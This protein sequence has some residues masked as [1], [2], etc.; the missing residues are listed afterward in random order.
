M[1]KV[2]LDVAPGAVRRRCED[3]DQLCPECGELDE[4]CG[5]C[6]LCA[7]W[8]CDCEE[9][10]FDADELGLDPEDDAARRYSHKEN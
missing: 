9:A 7:S 10:L 8:C 3:C 6:H 5:E 2:P 1:G 4:L